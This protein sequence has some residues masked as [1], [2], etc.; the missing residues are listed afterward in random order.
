MSAHSARAIGGVCWRLLSN[1]GANTETISSQNALT[2]SDKVW[3]GVP[4]YPFNTGSNTEAIASEDAF[5][6]RTRF[7]RVFRITRLLLVRIPRQ[8]RR[9]TRSLFGAVGLVRVRVASVVGGGAA[10]A[11]ALVPV[12]ENGYHS[13]P[14]SRRG[15]L[16]FSSL[17][18]G[19][20]TFVRKI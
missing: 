3:P 7:G 11:R 9:I 19:V 16:K 14:V 8:L 15:A 4:N 18:A 5:T 20:V 13:P 10:L 12:G 17:A 1:T 6:F 2:F